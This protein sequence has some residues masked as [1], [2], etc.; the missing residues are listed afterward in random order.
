MAIGLVLS[1]I[2]MGAA[3]LRE[4]KRLAVAKTNGG[5]NPL[6]ISVF[7]F[8]HSSFWWVLLMLSYTLASLISS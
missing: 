1:T 8:L 2:G 4:R 7:F 6:H 3:A 5:S